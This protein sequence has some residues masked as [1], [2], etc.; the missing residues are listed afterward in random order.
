MRLFN[1]DTDEKERY[2][3]INAISRLR[4]MIRM[5][6]YDDVIVYGKRS[7]WKARS[8]ANMIAVYEERLRELD[9][10]K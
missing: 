3:I 9:K 6:K 1:V 8:A 10:G 7:T 4:L 2:R 5:G